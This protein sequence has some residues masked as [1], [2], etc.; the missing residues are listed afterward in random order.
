M[1]SIWRRISFALVTASVLLGAVEGGAWFYERQTWV[2][3]RLYPVA[4]P[5][6]HMDFNKAAEKNRR[7]LM[8]GGTALVADPRMKWG[9]A[10]NTV[11]SGP[12]GSYRINSL[13]LRGPDLGEKAEGE[14][15]LM[16]LGD[17]SVYG[18]GVAENDVFIVVA[19][20]LLGHA[21]GRDVTGII[22][23]VPGHDTTQSMAML[24]KVGRGLQL[25]WVVVGNLWSDVF[26]DRGHAR[27]VTGRADTITGPMRKLA[28]YRVLRR[29]LSPKL[30]AR[31]I[32]FLA[33][34]EDVGS[35]T[36]KRTSRVLLS[37]YIQNLRKLTSQIESIGARPAFLILPAPMDLDPVPPPEAV[38][39][40]REVMRQAAAAVDAPLVDG[41]KLF[42]ERGVDIGFWTDQVHPDRPGHLLLG[43]G[44]FE[45]L[46]DHG[47]E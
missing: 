20:D 8:Q 46:K 21:W 12:R 42:L 17:S 3:E 41:P 40:Y 34:K 5:G 36:G 26:H 45:A 10:P 33:S 47:P 32:H 27:N 7:Q 14:L 30:R 9:L 19:A 6:R 2:S 1:A 4:G 22:G 15:R 43:D 38:L 25:D 37:E 29:W 18:D 16:S 24:A 31:E 44:L 28:T 35:L 23:G 11:Q 39:A 13:G